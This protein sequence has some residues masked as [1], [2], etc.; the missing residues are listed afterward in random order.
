MSG[1]GKGKTGISTAA[2]ELEKLK[3]AHPIIELI[4]EYREYDKLKN[5]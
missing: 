1:I 4:M 5:T 3:D 2:G